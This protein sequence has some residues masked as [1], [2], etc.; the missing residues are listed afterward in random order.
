[1]SKGQ[2]IVSD[3]V[4]NLKDRYQGITQELW[5]KTKND[6]AAVGILNSGIQ[7]IDTEVHHYERMQRLNL[8]PIL[9]ALI[10]QHEN[11]S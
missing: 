7:V 1:M 11:I 9:K 5:N 10:E 3:T 4:E 6:A 2:C 8:T